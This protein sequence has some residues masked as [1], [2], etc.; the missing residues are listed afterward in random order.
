MRI[1]VYYCYHQ[2]AMQ[3]FVFF[4]KNFVSYLSKMVF[5]IMSLVL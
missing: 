2:N 1:S 5:S 4:K 3:G